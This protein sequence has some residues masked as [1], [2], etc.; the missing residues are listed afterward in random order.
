[1]T[2]DDMTVSR[3]LRK[4]TPRDN[5]VFELGLFMGAIGRDRTFIVSPRKNDLKLP[6]DLLG[7]T[8]LSYEADGLKTVGRRMASVAKEVYNQISKRGPK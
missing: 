8:H 1:M 7:V 5:V 6:T 2:A 3:G 4:K